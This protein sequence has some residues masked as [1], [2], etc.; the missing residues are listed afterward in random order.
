MFVLARAYYENYE[1]D[2][3]VKMYDKIMSLTK[4]ADI[5]NAAQDLKKQVLD[6]SY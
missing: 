2:K 4:A 6:A 5:V 1:F 3:A